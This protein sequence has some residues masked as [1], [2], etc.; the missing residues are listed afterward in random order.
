MWSNSA[1]LAVGLATSVRGIMHAR[2]LSS[3][4]MW[5]IHA[6]RFVGIPFYAI[7]AADSLNALSHIFSN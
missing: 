2:N 1:G 3:Q 6:M 7:V 5:E 4:C